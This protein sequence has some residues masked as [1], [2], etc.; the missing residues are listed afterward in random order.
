MH[1]YVGNKYDNLLEFGCGP[2][3]HLLRFGNFNKNINLIGLNWTK[4][5]QTI[6]QNI[7]DL[8]LNNKITGHNFNFFT[9]DYNI[10]IPKNSAIF[11]CNALE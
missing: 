4:T 7:K 1:E 10:N 9:P 6:I 2:A 5:S 11:T 3:Y 8:N